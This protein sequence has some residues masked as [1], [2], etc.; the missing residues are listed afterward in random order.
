MRKQIYSGFF[1]NEI[2]ENLSQ[3]LSEQN[4]IRLLYHSNFSD[5]Q[6]RTLC[7][8]YIGIIKASPVERSDESIR[9]DMIKSLMYIKSNIKNRYNDVKTMKNIADC[10]R[11]ISDGALYIVLRDA[12]F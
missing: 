9:K 10:I 2:T 7:D 4:M 5:S 6:L 1:D 11:I 12:E 3:D 8:V